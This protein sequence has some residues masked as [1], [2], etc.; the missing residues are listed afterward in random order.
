[1]LRSF[2]ILTL[3]AS[4]V[5]TLSLTGCES[6]SS[7]NKGSADLDEGE[8]VSAPSSERK[9]KESATVDSEK[10]TTSSSSKAAQSPVVFVTTTLSNEET[11][12]GQIPQT[13]LSDLLRDMG[14]AFYEHN[15]DG[16]ALI[17]FLVFR[18]L[19]GTSRDFQ[20]ILERRSSL[21]SARDPWILIECAYTSLL[22]NDFGMAQYLLDTA[23]SVGKGKSMVPAAV[24]HA[25]GLL[26]L[27]QKK[28]VLAMAAFRE[29]A[30][31]SYEPAILTLAF[32]AIKIGD[33]AGA[34]NQLNKIKDSAGGNLNV[35]AALGIAYRQAGK[36][37]EALQY[38][39]GV[40]RFRPEDKG[41][42]WNI[43]LAL[44]DIPEK[45]RE[46]IAILEKYVASPGGLLDI[47]TKARNLLSKLSS[48]EEEAKA[49][50]SREK[51]GGAQ[52]SGKSGKN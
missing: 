7:S 22:R 29:S 16:G 11:F 3:L 14:Q 49:S 36:A 47:D 21:A 46:A 50:A 42:L 48:L 31:L 30:K 52:S 12:L 39:N 13:K 45:R 38:L 33:H 1:M 37:E 41:I 35:R 43:A 40:L 26:Y 8:E 34:L 15:D 24:L 19:S 9:A 10:P 4:T 25:R 44:A 2:S 51:A 18:R 28:T 6:T 5:F 20:Q 17:S 32:S 27:K 23:E